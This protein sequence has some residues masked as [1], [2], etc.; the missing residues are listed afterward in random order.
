MQFIFFSLQYIAFDSPF[1]L[2]GIYCYNV[3]CDPFVKGPVFFFFFC[4]LIRLVVRVLL[5]LLFTRA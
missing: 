3:L 5:L 2:S 4:R 1:Q